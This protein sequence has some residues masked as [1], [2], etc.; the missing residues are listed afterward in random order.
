MCLIIN[1]YINKKKTSPLELDIYIPSHNLAIEF[2]GLYW[3]SEIHK[4]SNYHLNKTE[5]CEEH[6]I[7][8]CGTMV[9]KKTPT[10]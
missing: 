4:P 5:L 10:Y 1:I 2:D 7:Y 3:H 8:D 6:R 9:Y